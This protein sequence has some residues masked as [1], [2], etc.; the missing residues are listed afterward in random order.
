[1]NKFLFSSLLILGVT[2]SAQAEDWTFFSKKNNNSNSNYG[3]ALIAGSADLDKHDSS[4]DLYG[5]EFSL[6]CPF[7]QAS[8]HIIRQQISLT[9]FHKNN[10]D[11]YTL[12]VNPHYLYQL[13]SN[14]Y[15][16]M[17][18]SVGISRANGTDDNL[19]ISVGAGVSL[20][21]DMTDELFL[22]AEFRTV[23]AT[24]SDVDNVRV[25]AKVGYYFDE[26][27]F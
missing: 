1:M 26:L 27:P 23:Y 19:V 15:F 21:K 4:G 13:E 20:R 7:V 16:G 17:G 3:L 14:T 5:L 18:P 25:I 6:V 24:E 11:L 10:V 12:E 22:A 2:F 9:K 8:E